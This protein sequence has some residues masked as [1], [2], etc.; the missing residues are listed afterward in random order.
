M[1]R[2]ALILIPPAVAVATWAYGVRAT[3]GTEEAPGAGAAAA[4]GSGET[5]AGP[6]YASITLPE[7]WKAY[8]P[9]ERFPADRMF[10][11]I[12]GADE[13][14]LR[15]GVRELIYKGFETAGGDAADV[16]IYDMGSEDAATVMFTEDSGMEPGTR[17]GFDGAIAVAE[18]TAYLRC[19]PYYVQIFASAEEGTD[20]ALAL[21][22]DVDRILTAGV[23]A[24]GPRA[25]DSRAEMQRRGDPEP[26]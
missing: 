16:F 26:E 8:G 12:D 20:V 25:G 13:A 22:R 6:D 2:V 17:E 3:R 24:Q 15:H 23:A 18:S 7:P 5:V 10:E 21:A 4:A 9:V 14:F 19:G 1:R 11:K